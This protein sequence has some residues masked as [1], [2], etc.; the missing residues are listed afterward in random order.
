MSLFALLILLQSAHAFAVSTP[1]PTIVQEATS[2]PPEPTVGLSL[3][4]RASASDLATR[5][6][7]W[8]SSEL[9]DDESK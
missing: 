4:R 8:V 3:N 9:F 7:G 6:C 2:S 5:R 1:K